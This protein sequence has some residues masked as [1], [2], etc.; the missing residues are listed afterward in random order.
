M[1]LGFK[2]V[3]VVLVVVVAAGFVIVVVPVCVVLGFLGCVRGLR[4]FGRAWVW[5]LGVWWVA[6]CKAATIR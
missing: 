2:C 3:V 6:R 4:V 1:D 5:G